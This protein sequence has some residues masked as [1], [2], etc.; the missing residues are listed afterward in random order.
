MKKI[1][2]L[3]FAVACIIMLASCNKYN[4][5]LE[6]K[7]TSNTRE[8]VVFECTLNDDKDELANSELSYKICEKGSD[9]AVDFGTITLSANNVGSFT[10]AGLES[11][12]E[13]TIKIT[14]GFEGKE[15]VL[16]D[17]TFKATQSGVSYDP[18]LISTVDEFKT[19]LKNDPTGYFKLANDI[20]FEGVFY[21]PLFN[22]STSFTGTLDG[23]GHSLKNFKTEADT[24]QTVSTTY[25]G[26]I[27]Y[28]GASGVVKNIT[29]EDFNV[30]LYYGSQCFFATLAGYNA[31][32]VENVTVKNTTLKGTGSSLDY[33][34]G[35]IVAY[36]AS[37]ATIKNCMV[38]STVKLIATSNRSFFIGGIAAKSATPSVSY[39]ENYIDSC[40]FAGEIEVAM[41]SR[42]TT[43]YQT[44]IVVGGII[45]QN[46]STVRNSTAMGSIK[47]T[48]GFATVGSVYNIVVG[49]IAG[50]N[51]NNAS[52]VVSAI[53]ESSFDITSYDAKNVTL[54]LIVGQNGGSNNSYSAQVRGEFTNSGKDII[55]RVSE[56]AVVK[57]GLVGIDKASQYTNATV[58]SDTTIVVEKYASEELTGNANILVQ[59]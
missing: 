28:I 42:S 45:G 20:D 52:K 22:A 53:V 39:K 9:T 16:Y 43:A 27:G 24:Q 59:K 48:S 3:V 57:G 31:G 19:M 29:I 34:M 44:N 56:T 17:S 5:S 25:Q 21:A 2:C 51:M 49:G 18:Y 35:G 37:N 30:N 33:F 14:T 36:N 47:V 58:S 15:V 26:I 41:E 13:Y 38:E 12:H 40:V 11:G 54:G 55:L 50:E 7:E 32:T 8:K 1:L 46:F 4:F 10:A 23:D 6:V